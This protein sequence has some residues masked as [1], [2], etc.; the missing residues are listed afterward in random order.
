VTDECSEQLH[1][2]VHVLMTIV[3]DLQC[4]PTDVKQP[5]LSTH[6]NSMEMHFDQVEVGQIGQPQP[7]LPAQ[8]GVAIAMYARL[9]T[10]VRTRLEIR[11]FMTS[12]LKN[13]CPHPCTRR[14]VPDDPTDPD[15]LK[16]YEE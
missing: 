9:R 15:M 5:H 11:L 12:P 2:P 13:K 16:K 4:E 3:S 1:L 14:Q 7:Q 10:T 6:L 8:A